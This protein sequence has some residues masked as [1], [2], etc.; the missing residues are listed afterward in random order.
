M[1]LYD[2]SH[3]SHSQART[4][5]QR[6]TLELR[7]ALAQITPLEDITY[8]PYLRHWRKLEKWERQSL[9][10]VPSRSGKRGAYWPIRTQL[11]G[12]MS[13]PFA[14][15]HSEPKLSAVPSGFLTAEIFTPRTGKN[16]PQL[17][18]R[19]KGPKVAIFHDA[20][21]MRMPQLAPSG[22][23]G[24]F[25]G[26][27]SELR[28]FDGI[29]AVSED[30]RQSLIDY[31]QWAGWPNTPP[32]IVSGLG[33]DHI[34]RRA[35]QTDSTISDPQRLPVVLSVGSI[36]GRKNHL[37]L[38]DAA[39]DLWNAGESFELRIIG[40]AQRETGKSALARIKDL[41]AAGRPLV[42]EGWLSDDDL[43]LAYQSC[44]F[45]VYP[46]LME[47]FGLPVWESLLN[48]APCICSHHGAT[49]ETAK[50]GGCVTVDTSVKEQLAQAMQSLLNT[51]AQLALL[52]QQAQQRT[53]P[54]WSECAQRIKDW[55]TKI[56]A[57]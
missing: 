21:S 55:M 25:P 7:K 49:S 16:L 5:V 38:L 19:I 50:D 41:Q 24:R 32:V 46:S 17:F 26:Y 42:Y 2:L 52:R 44:S 45:T 10:Q 40:T 31:W 43:K 11:K 13:R 36:E 18:E 3:T 54:T 8:D 33:L 35:S 6:V 22:T 4:G 51:P 57:E 1:L 34:E 9:D 30:S 14:S 12:W 20:I 28:Q 53:P 47:G 27:L 15:S 37:T 23:V 48:A 29:V 39:E 56:P